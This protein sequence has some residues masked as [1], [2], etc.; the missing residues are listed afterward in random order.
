MTDL[1]RAM[2]ASEEGQWMYVLDAECIDH[3][4]VCE[5]YVGDPGVP[6]SEWVKASVVIEA[7]DLPEVIEYQ[8]LAWDSNDQLIAN[9]GGT[10]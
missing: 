2:L 7:S 9:N 6:M 5:G 3:V 10:K 1:T 8:S 4:I